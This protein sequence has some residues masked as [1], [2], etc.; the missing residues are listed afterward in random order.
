MRQGVG[1]AISIMGA[2]P[3]IEQLHARRHREHRH[4]ARHGGRGPL[5]RRDSGVQ[6]TD[7]DVLGRVRLQLQPDQHHQ[8]VGHERV[9]RI[10]VRLHPQREAGRAQLLRPGRCGRSPSS[11]RSSRGSSSAVR[12]SRTRRSSSFNYEG[13]ADRAR[14]QLVLQRADPR[15]AGGPLHDARSSIRRPGSPSRT[16]PFRSRGILAAGAAGRQPSSFRRRTAC[17]HAGQLPDRSGRCHRIR[18]SSRFAST[19]I[20]AA[21]GRCSDASRKPPSTTSRRRASADLGD[22]AVQQDSTNWQLS[23][24]WVVHSNLVNNFRLGRVKATANQGASIPADPADVTALGLT[25]VFTDLT[26][27]QRALPAHQHLE[28]LLAAGR[29]HQRLHGQLPA[30]VGPQ[31]HDDVG[32]GAITHST[33][34]S[35]SASGR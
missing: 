30:D 6:G 31:Q 23:H 1:S 28:H 27:A 18:I 3:D 17:G 22:T 19:T 13:V 21:T 7:V 2:R 32:E 14:V 15:P 20:S 26:D 24:T 25:G 4:V 16:T 8:Q 9:P 29:R 11:I 10:G 12:S 34:D 33:R 35:T 5:D